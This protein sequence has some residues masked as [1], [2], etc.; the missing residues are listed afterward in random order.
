MTVTYVVH[1]EYILISFSIRKRTYE[2]LLTLRET[3]PSQFEELTKNDPLYPLLPFYMLQ[4]ITR[5]IKILL[6]LVDYCLH[7]KGFENVVKDN[8]D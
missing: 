5:R 6:A 2:R 4:D 7:Y 1:P 8:F 3:L